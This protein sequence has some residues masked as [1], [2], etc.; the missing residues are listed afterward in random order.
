MNKIINVAIDG[1]AGAGKSTIAK[2]VSGKLGY[3]YVDTGALYRAVA[4]FRIE[5][6]L[7][8]VNKLIERLPECC[9]EL[10]FVDGIQKVYL[11][12]R[13]VSEDIRKNSVSMMAS[14]TSAIVQVREF[15]FGLQKK[16]ASE[17]SVIMDGRDIGTVVLPDAQVKIFLTASPEER[18]M[19][20]YRELKDKPGCPDFQTL[21]AEI[22]KRDEND[23]NRAVAPLKKAPDA[24][25]IDSTSM[26][27]EETAEKIFQI[28]LDK[29]LKRG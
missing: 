25:E 29:T 26:S 11:N 4:L 6:S 19:R 15:L 14:E 2:M 20:R 13:D 5:N 8:D 21:L 18:A 23:M 28:I 17:N 12:N 7:D 24:V 16:I 27:L 1:P 3:I 9:V 22:I 10:K